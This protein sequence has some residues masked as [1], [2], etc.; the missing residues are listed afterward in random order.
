MAPLEWEGKEV[1]ETQ[2]P[3]K[4]SC[5]RNLSAA[6]TEFETCADVERSAGIETKLHLAA[7]PNRSGQQGLNAPARV[8]TEQ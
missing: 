7:E 2:L 4:L 1:R 6:E 5:R 3:P 8:S